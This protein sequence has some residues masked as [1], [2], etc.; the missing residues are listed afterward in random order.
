MN[1]IYI[2]GPMRGYP[3][4]NFPAFA[5]ATDYFRGL[6]WEVCNPAEKDDDTYG[7]EMATT[8]LTGSVEEAE[9]EHGFSIRDALGYDLNWICKNATHIYMLK[10]W[11]K[12]RGAMAEHATA[13][14]L[15]LEIM[16]EQG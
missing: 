4:F 9:K 1:K 14:A 3:Q 12:S 6:G 11:E 2:A 5:A 10:G 13:V 15:G 8:N 16:Y 7:K